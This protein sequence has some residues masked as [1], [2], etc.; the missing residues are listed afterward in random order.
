MYMSMSLVRSSGDP[1]SPEVIVEERVD[2]R[3]PGTRRP[4]PRHGARTY[5]RFGLLLPLAKR[6]SMEVRNQVRVA[7]TG[8]Q[9][10]GVSQV[11]QAMI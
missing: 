8:N 3:S 1:G 4:G 5:G 6:R 9:A 11:G 7:L 10:P 2:P